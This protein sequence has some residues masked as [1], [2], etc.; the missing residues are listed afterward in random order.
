MR[1]PT[2]EEINKL[3]N[4]LIEMRFE[5]FIHQDFLSPQWWFLLSIGPTKQCQYFLS[6]DTIKL[7]YSYVVLSK[8]N[9]TYSGYLW[10][11][12]QYIH[13]MLNKN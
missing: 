4:Q 1:Y 12:I 6:Y 9:T 8:S 5:N 13:N 11:N 3:H 7:T 10:Y 2:Q